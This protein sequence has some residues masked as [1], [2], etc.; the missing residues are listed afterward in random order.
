[1]ILLLSSRFWQRLAPAPQ[2][3]LASLFSKPI[4]KPCLILRRF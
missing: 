3:P 2:F 4:P 1:M